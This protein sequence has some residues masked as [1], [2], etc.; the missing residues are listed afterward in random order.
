MI[1][2]NFIYLLLHKEIDKTQGSKKL[3]MI[4]HKEIERLLESEVLYADIQN[5]MAEWYWSGSLNY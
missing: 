3:N 5:M 2:R 1:N 4:L